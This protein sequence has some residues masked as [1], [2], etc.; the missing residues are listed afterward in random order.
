M[1]D[2]ADGYTGSAPK[3][4]RKANGSRIR[5]QT[6][7]SSA[8]IVDTYIRRFVRFFPEETQ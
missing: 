5:R 3:F 8:I 6:R 1:G 7:L 2:V 4:A